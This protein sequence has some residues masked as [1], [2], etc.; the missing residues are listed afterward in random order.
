MAGVPGSGVRAAER[1]EPQRIEVWESDAEKA[2]ATAA[3]L[4]A[5]AYGP[6]TPLVFVWPCDVGLGLFAR[7][8]LCA[9]DARG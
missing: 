8:P 5:A 3:L 7:V 2:G 4:T 6:I 1:P 9:G